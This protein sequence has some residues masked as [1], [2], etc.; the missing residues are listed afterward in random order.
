M[1]L[2]GELNA[3]HQVQPLLARPRQRPIVAGQRIVIGDRQGFQ[4]HG[5]RRID[6]FKRT[7]C[8]VGFVSVR[9]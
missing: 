5:D 3:A 4:A 1:K 9:V 2:G 7:V 6:Q 8:A